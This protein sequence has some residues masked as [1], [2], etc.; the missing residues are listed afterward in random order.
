MISCVLNFLII[1][2]VKFTVQTINLLVLQGVGSIHT[3]PA[4]YLHESVYPCSSGSDGTIWATFIGVFAI[5]WNNHLKSENT[6]LRFLVTVTQPLLWFAIAAHICENRPLPPGMHMAACN[7]VP[8]IFWNCRIDILLVFDN[9]L[10]VL[11]TFSTF[12]FGR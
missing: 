10:S 9:F 7:N 3:P 1:S 4:A 8:A 5:C 11:T 12:V 6:T 2:G